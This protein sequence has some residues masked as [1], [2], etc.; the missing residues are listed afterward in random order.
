MFIKYLNVIFIII[1]AITSKRPGED[2]T[3]FS[4]TIGLMCTD[5][6]NSYEKKL[7]NENKKQSANQSA[8]SSSTA[9]AK[10]NQLNQSDHSITES[11]GDDDTK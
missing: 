3:L 1:A 11:D 10:D 6:K 2:S 9:S 4:K 5:K 8:S 7:A